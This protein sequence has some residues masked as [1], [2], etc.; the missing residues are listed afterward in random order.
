MEVWEDRV[1]SMVLMLQRYLGSSMFPFD[2]CGWQ[3]GRAIACTGQIDSIGKRNQYQ[4]LLNE[5]NKHI[6]Q[7]WKEADKAGKALQYE[8]QFEQEDEKQ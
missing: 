7:L 4:S 6:Q 5:A 8:P 2:V 1:L 3:S